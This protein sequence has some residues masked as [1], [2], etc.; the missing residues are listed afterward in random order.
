MYTF[1]IKTIKP[2]SLLLYSVAVL[3]LQ[4]LTLFFNILL[5]VLLDKLLVGDQLDTQI[6]Y[7]IRLFQSST[8]FEQT[9]AHHQEV[10]C[11]NTVSGVVTLCKWLSGMQVETFRG[12]K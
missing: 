7:I 3:H 11:I 1:R 6:F 8:C 9:R 4:P 5:T 10:N 2:A 12:F